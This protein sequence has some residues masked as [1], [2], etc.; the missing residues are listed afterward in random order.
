MT[1]GVAA[2]D[3]GARRPIH[4]DVPVTATQLPDDPA[5]MAGRQPR[6]AALLGVVAALSPEAQDA[7]LSECLSRAE[8]AQRLA[9]LERRLEQMDEQRRA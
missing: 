5:Q 6:V 7:V 8:A 1:T 2:P 9:E 4:D 3:A